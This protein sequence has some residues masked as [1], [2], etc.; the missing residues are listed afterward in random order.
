MEKN[1]EYRHDGVSSIKK[2]ENEINS[3]VTDGVHMSEVNIE[4]DK[5]RCNAGVITTGTLHA[6]Q[7]YV[8]NNKDNDYNKMRVELDCLSGRITQLESA[9]SI[10]YS[11]ISLKADS[12]YVSCLESKVSEIGNK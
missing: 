3:Q 9:I 10:L 7:I 6:D 2:S 1:V 5:I 12:L 11:E 8:S 4:E